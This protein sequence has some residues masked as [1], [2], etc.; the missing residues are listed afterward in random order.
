MQVQD[1][2]PGAEAEERPDP[3]HEPQETA[4]LEPVIARVIEPGGVHRE[5]LGVHA[6]RAQAARQERRLA[7]DLGRGVQDRSGRPALAR[8]ALECFMRLGAEPRGGD[9]RAPAMPPAPPRSF[10]ARAP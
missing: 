1:V 7:G 4:A 10:H 6:E 2:E 8:L 9:R 5:R 3:L